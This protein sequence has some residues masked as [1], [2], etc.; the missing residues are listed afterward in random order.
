L[1]PR[2]A[3][4]TRVVHSADEVCGTRIEPQAEHLWPGI[5]SDAVEQLARPDG[6]VQVEVGI[7]DGLVISE[8]PSE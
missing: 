7:E 6:L 5:V 3:V 2:R 4:W 8:R 1:T